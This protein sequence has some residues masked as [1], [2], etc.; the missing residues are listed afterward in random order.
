MGLQLFRRLREV[1]PNIRLV[2]RDIDPVDEIMGLLRTQRLDLAV[3][4]AHFDSPTLEQSTFMSFQAVLIARKSHPRV[5][6]AVGNMERAAG[7]KNG[8][9]GF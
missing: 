3:H 9:S 5:Y 8:G 1:A 4:H 2:I 7:G 6:S